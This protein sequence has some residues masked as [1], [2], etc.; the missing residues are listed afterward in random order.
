MEDPPYE[1]V[2]T[3]GQQYAV[4]SMHPIADPPCVKFRDDSGNLH[5]MHAEHIRKWFLR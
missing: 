3:K 5:R 1:R 2:F 4:V